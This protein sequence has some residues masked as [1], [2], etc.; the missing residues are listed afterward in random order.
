MSDTDNVHPPKQHEVRKLQLKSLLFTQI[1]LIIMFVCCAVLAYTNR[2][3]AS[4]IN[5][6]QTNNVKCVNEASKCLGDLEA[7]IGTVNHCTDQFRSSVE[8]TKETLAELHSCNADL[9]A[10]VD[11]MKKQNKDRSVASN[12]YLAC[13]E[14]STY[15]K[16]QTIIA[17]SRAS[18]ALE[19][20]EAENQRLQKL[21]VAPF[22]TAQPAS[23][24]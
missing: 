3:L 9:A 10:L 8:D 23:S 16:K 11:E 21:L 15:D 1:A 17:L 18:F 4:V 5:D 24:H 2:R 12:Q 19:T 6:L 14:Q 7:T 13:L 22:P 20:C